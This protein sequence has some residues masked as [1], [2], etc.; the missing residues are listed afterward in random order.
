MVILISFVHFFVVTA[1]FILLDK[2]VVALAQQ[3]LRKQSTM[4][5]GKVWLWTNL[6]MRGLAWCCMSR[7]ATIT[8]PEKELL[9]W[10]SRA[11]DIL[12]LLPHN[13]PER[14]FCLAVWSGYS[15]TVKFINEETF[16]VLANKLLQSINHLLRC[17]KPA[18]R[19]SFCY[20]N[21]CYFLLVVLVLP[22][23]PQAACVTEQYHR[24]C[25]LGSNTYCTTVMSATNYIKT[26]NAITFR[27]LPAK[28]WEKIS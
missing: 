6:C 13:T 14:V 3:L 24:R 21:H 10:L 12:V 2:Q 17:G 8:T 15:P 25:W 11:E 26:P 4:R 16:S 27:S 9:T 18:Y 22:L 5:T 23:L 20:G 7:H 19:A 28:N 1:Q